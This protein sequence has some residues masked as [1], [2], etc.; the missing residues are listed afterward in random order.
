M[1]L[2]F[3]DNLDFCRTCVARRCSAE[4]GNEEMGVSGAA[5]PRLKGVASA[6]GRDQ[7]CSAS[8]RYRLSLPARTEALSEWIRGSRRAK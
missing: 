1:H 6:K 3:D 7:N 4:N 2:S 8:S 5:T